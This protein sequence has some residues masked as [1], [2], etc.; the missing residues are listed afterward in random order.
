LQFVC[1]GIFS[2][3]PGRLPKKEFRGERIAAEGAGNIFLKTSEPI[4][5]LFKICSPLPSR[6]GVRGWVKLQHDDVM[7]T[8][9][10]P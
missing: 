9:P 3:D 10:P 4:A 6:E 1:H 7:A 8:F 5:K 2:N